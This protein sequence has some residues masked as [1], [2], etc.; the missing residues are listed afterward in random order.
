[1]L[2]EGRVLA[3]V[4]ALAH[5]AGGERAER[6]VWPGASLERELGLG[7]LERVEL[8]LRLEHEFGG[9]LDES[10]LGLDSAREIAQALAE[11]DAAVDWAAPA[12]LPAAPSAPILDLA[13][14]VTTL[15]AALLHRAQA[16]PERVHVWLPDEPDQ[17]QRTITYG[18][19][20]AEAQALA[21]GL[22]AQ[23]VQRGD[24]VALMLP[25]GLEFLASFLGVQIAGAIPV[26]LYP[27]LRLDRLD[28]YAARQSAILRDAGVRLLIAFPRALPIASLLA[29]A[30]PSLRSVVTVTDL[31]AF[32]V[33]APASP[34]EASDTAL[35]QYTSGSTGD[36]KGVQLTHAQL[37]DNIRAI[38]AH[39]D[40]RPDDV[41]VSWLPLYHDMGL[42]GAW[43]SSLYHAVPLALLSPLAFLARPERWL[44]LIHQ[45]RA[46]LSAAP[47]FAYEL[48]A[49]KVSDAVIDGLDL[50]SWRC[51]LNGAE[52]VNPDTL[53]R[54]AHRFARAG[55]RREAFVP[56]YGLAENS[57][58]LCFPPLGRVPRVDAVRRVDFETRGRAEVAAADEASALRFVSVGRPL[59]GH[60]VRLIDQSGAEVPERAVG[61]L[62]FRGPSAMSGY[63]HRP[64][65]TAAVTLPDGWID[66]GDLAYR[67]DGEIFIAGRIK[68]LIIKGGRNLVPQEIEEAA[69]SVPHVRR[70]CVVAFG[71]ASQ[72]L[73]TERLVIVAETRLRH[74]AERS[75]LVTAVSER[76][77]K[78]VGVPPDTVVLV[79]PHS[80]PKTSS[81]KVR[82]G[83]AR[84]LYLSRR[85]GRASSALATRLKLAVASA[86]HALRRLR[87]LTRV[88]Y[89]VY[90]GVVA[91]AMLLCFWLPAVVLPGRRAA[92][93]LARW[94]SRVFLR[95]L[96]CRLS[97]EGL[98]QLR[99]L[100]GPLVLACNHAS[101][102]DA[103]VLLALLPR[104]VAFVA[105]RE[106]FDWPLVGTFARK[107][108][109]LPV[110]RWDVHQSV[111]DAQRIGEALDAGETL[112]FFPEGT[113][114][115]AT[116]LRSFRLG[117][118]KAA[119]DARCPIVPVALVG[120]RRVLRGDA[121]LPRPGPLRMWVGQPVDPPQTGGFRAL[122]E[123]RDRVAVAIAAHCGEPCLDMVSS[124]LRRAG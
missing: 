41:T 13:P 66:S 14:D 123:L 23:G 101:N 124:T 47:N 11:R 12:T 64:E 44:T 81:G 43:L 39:L 45:Q 107:G 85:L 84:E 93:T 46:T 110:D 92:R 54:F 7:S 121:W 31:K 96:G 75:A 74:A 16:A 1:M 6:A 99:G 113:F 77:A 40:L 67:A 86:A 62:V 79:P 10:F 49:R 5:E 76:V 55:F 106:V 57:V 20:L 28:E 58:A 8:L 30:V 88:P 115:A 24:T 65:A 36:P 80:V 91:L 33:V 70:G 108:A 104:N 94:G 42:I 119:V 29:P 37:I 118:F 109:H 122:V 72:T 105:K 69:S 97:C 22:Q 26:P 83:A 71:V 102:I 2:D 90:V 63:Y 9:P 87:V 35:V 89:A 120:T 60:A 51:A 95:M 18:R 117:A 100:R 25:T 38:G 21:G 48:C 114:T 111:A 34:G 15:V 112:V 3:V 19:L 59:S 17:G 61:R 68:D 98:A 52:P 73:G 56:A 32:G 4:R 50:S 116:G 53:E 82:R 103:L 78:A 27:P